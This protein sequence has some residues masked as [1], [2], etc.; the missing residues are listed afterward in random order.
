MDGGCRVTRRG[1]SASMDVAV[2]RCAARPRRSASGRVG[3]D[4]VVVELVEVVGGGDEPPFASAC[5]SAAALEAS[6]RAVGLDL[7]EHRLDG[8][9]PVAVEAAPGGRGE[10]AAHE[11]VE[12]AGPAG[13]GA[14]AQ[15]GVGRDEDLDAVADDRFD[16][17]VMPVAGAGDDDL[18]VTD[19][20]R[21]E[22]ASGG[23]DHR[24]QMPEVG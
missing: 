8:H 17:A 6:D 1:G 24:L 23:A 5:R 13:P 14:L 16:L 3:G 22:L 20:E 18:G 15:A 9:L 19:V 4:A 2:E 7:A 10:D 12:P 11:V 21:V